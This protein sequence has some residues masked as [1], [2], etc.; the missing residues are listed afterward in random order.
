MN[1]KILHCIMIA[2]IALPL[3]ASGQKEKGSGADYPKKAI[4]MIVPYGA[5]GTTDLTGRKFAIN[6]QKE[7]G[8]P[9]TVINQSGASGSVGAKAVLD[10]KPDGY[11]VFF[12]AESLGTQRVM[13]ISD[14]SYAD[15]SPIMAVVNDPKVIVV[16]K[17]SPYKTLSDLLDDMKAHPNKIKMSYTGPGGSG[18]V[19]GLIFTQLG[20]VPAMTAYSSGADCI[21]SVLGHQVDFT[22]SNY[23]TIVGYLK[24]GDLK[25]L[26]V[27]SS[28]RLTTY[29]N[30]PTL[31]DVDPAA[32]KYMDTAF[33][34]LSFLVDKDVPA[35]IEQILRDAALK[36]VQEDAWKTYVH[37]NSLEELYVQYPSIEDINQFYADWESRTTW[38]LSD[39]GATKRSPE[40][41]NIPHPTL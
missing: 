5:G 17:D 37:D 25:L 23:S 40:E 7:L 38:L 28:R 16:A 36:V 13:E 29:P 41:F 4:T 35:D 1:K 18:H 33:S 34:P 14:M 30:V 32:V 10:A 24:S 26:G 8:V 9:V 3:F 12:T 31:G 2:C 6:L 27:S 20:Y 21:V 19:Q 15:F 22:N 39:A 11:T